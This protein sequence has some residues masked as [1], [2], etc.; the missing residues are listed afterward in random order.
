M[1]QLY[2]LSP[3]PLG[4]SIIHII[5][6]LSHTTVLHTFR[7]NCHIFPSSLFLLYSRIYT[8]SPI[9]RTPYFS[10]PSS[11]SRQATQITPLY[12]HRPLPLSPFSILLS[13]YPNH[14]TH[15]YAQSEAN[16]CAHRQN[17]NMGQRL[18]P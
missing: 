8:T 17:K 13:M 18:K 5:P 3:Y 1:K 12:K 2:T 10:S 11:Q 9:M 4:S 16:R 7:Q 6:R 14:F 15:L